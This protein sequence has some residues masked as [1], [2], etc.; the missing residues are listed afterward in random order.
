MSQ[1][2]LEHVGKKYGKKCILQDISVTFSSGKVYGLIGENGAGKT[3]LLR[4]ICGLSSATEGTV[5]CDGKQVGKD[6]E[7]LE[8][9]GVIIETPGFLLNRTGFDNLL[10]LDSLTHKP[11]VEK[12]NHAMQICGL[13]PESRKKVGTYSLGMRQ[14]LGIAQAIMDAPGILILD[15]PTNGLDQQGIRDV[16]R[17][18][19]DAKT[20]KK[21][22]ILASHHMEEIE[23]LCDEVF[24]IQ[25]HKFVKRP[26]REKSRAEENSV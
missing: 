7:F 21:L 18:I 5:L 23:N 6:V 14:R 19:K 20:N 22:V 1:I 26:I 16:S 3:V 10:Y 4:I 25:E 12:V 8:N 17:I 9:C 15:E 2:V 24:Q 13:D 11:N